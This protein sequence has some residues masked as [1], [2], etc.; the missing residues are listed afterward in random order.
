MGMVLFQ[1]ASNNYLVSIQERFRDSTNLVGIGT[2]HK[3]EEFLLGLKS[4]QPD[5]YQ[6]RYWVIDGYRFATERYFG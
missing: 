3:V 1:T 2:H 5:T 6:D 4:E